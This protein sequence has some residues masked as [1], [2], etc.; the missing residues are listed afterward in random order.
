MFMR[1][2]VFLLSALVCIIAST[3]AAFAI[4]FLAPKLLPDFRRYNYGPKLA[5][6]YDWIG[7]TPGEF[8]GL[9]SFNDSN[10]QRIVAS[11][12]RGLVLLTV[13]DPACP[14][15]RSSRDQMDYL[16]RELKGLK[17][18]YYL[19]SLSPNVTALDMD[20]YVESLALE[21]KSF[22]WTGEERPSPALRKMV[23][24]SHLLIDSQ[25]EVI[26]TFPG[27]SV[28]QDVRLLMAKEVMRQVRKQVDFRQRLVNDGLL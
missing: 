13:V 24:P 20:A 3:A 17:V 10:G 2:K 23:S 12:P 21:V 18:D 27:T 8:I 1:Y 22:V 16:M 15:A 26:Q 7:P 25:G 19:A 9:P 11:T 14:A 5:R 6:G 28:Y 4:S